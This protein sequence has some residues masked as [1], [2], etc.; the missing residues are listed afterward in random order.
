MCGFLVVFS[1]KENIIKYKKLF[2]Q[3]LE[4]IHHR[5]PDNT[6]FYIDRNCYIGFKRLRILDISSLA[7]QPMISQ[8]GR[9]LIDHS[10][11]IFTARVCV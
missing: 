1:K 2:N 11:K 8:N 6:K 5:G 9:I 7:D 10:K 3:S 4:L